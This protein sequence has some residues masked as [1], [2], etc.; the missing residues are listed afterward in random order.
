M[1][2]WSFFRLPFYFVLKLAFLI[3]LMHPTQK[4]AV[5]IYDRFLRQFLTKYE[6]TIDRKVEEFTHKATK[7][8]EELANRATPE[9]RAAFGE[10][11]K[12]I[13]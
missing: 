11:V 12:K 6:N 2:F 5:V 13:D 8:A 4:G 9:V 3:Y 10:A 1:G 7:T